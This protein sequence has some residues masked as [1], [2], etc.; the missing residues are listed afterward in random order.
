MQFNSIPNA[1]RVPF[2]YVEFSNTETGGGSPAQPYK[3]LLIG[4]KLNA[5]TQA[6]NALVRVSS[7]KQAN[8]L[9]GSGSMLAG[10][11]RKAYAAN[12]FTEI[13]CIALADNASGVTA[14]GS[15]TLTGPATAD[16]TL[17][18]YI[19]GQ[20]INVGVLQGDTATVIATK[21]QAAIAGKPESFLTATV[22][23]TD[24]F[25]VNLESRHKGLV[26]NAAPVSLNYNG[27][28]TPAGVAVTI[29]ALAGGTLN[30]D[31][32]TAIE[33]IGDEQFRTIVTP[34]NDPANL[35]LLKAEL[36]RRWGPLLT[37]DGHAFA[38]STLGSAALASLGQAHNH[39]HLSILGVSASPTP[40][41]EI[42]AVLGAVVSY[43][44]PIDQARP[45]QTL[46]LP[47]VLAPK[48]E[49]RLILEERN[50][51][52]YTGIATAT[53]DA[54]NQVRLERLIT[55]YREDASGNIDESYLD[56]ETMAILSYLRWDFRRF[57]GNKYP[58]HKLAKDGVRFG[59]QQPIM[60][61]GLAKAEA[62]GLFERWEL[63]GLVED[64]TQFERDLRVE[65]NPNNPNRLDFYLPPNLINGLRIVAAQIAFRA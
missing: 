2:S 40:S 13:W 43:Y 22:D 17:S 28:V 42:A 10:M 8:T 27:E 31:I 24:L 18:I 58:R 48:V 39:P 54:D 38:A 25:K 63:N 5:G 37:N 26:A 19:G 14:K 11:F 59:T 65:V 49:D 36:S 16:G 29:G 32:S 52:L 12:N 35:T 45:L 15:L 6:V 34:Y 53:V 7:P 47:G 61:P 33:A 23:G 1:V 21:I 62:I 55:T 41:W 46:T 57:F 20:A 64:H 50:V 44:S 30:P 60:T 9:F 56:Y 4:Q 51:L 3:L